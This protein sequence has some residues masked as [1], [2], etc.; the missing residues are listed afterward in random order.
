M[1]AVFTPI[2]SEFESPEQQAAYEQWLKAK[3]QASLAKADD[4]NTPRY[5]TDEVAQR[6]SA[7]IQVAEKKHA[8]SRLA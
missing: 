3:V 1:S 4:P 7:I 8:A 6:M 2:E 5:S